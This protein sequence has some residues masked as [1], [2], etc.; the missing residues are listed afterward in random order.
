MLE[1]SICISSLHKRATLKSCLESLFKQAS[2]FQVSIAIVGPKPFEDSRIQWV[3]IP[4]ANVSLARN[5][6]LKEVQ[7]QVVYF[8]DDDCLLTN[9]H[10]LTNILKFC[11]S[12]QKPVL[13]FG[14]YVNGSNVDGNTIWQRTYNFICNLWL[15]KGMRLPDGPHILGG[16]FFICLEEKAEKSELQFDEQF[17][18]GAEEQGFI[19][20]VRQKGIECCY[21]PY[22]SIQHVVDGG[23]RRFFLRAWCHGTVKNQF[24]QEYLGFS[25]KI[26]LF[27]EEPESPIVKTLALLYL[28]IVYARSLFP[29]Y[30][31]LKSGT[32][33]KGNSNL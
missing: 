5:T 4:E 26:Q 19:R 15:R 30:F 31:L 16:N 13:G 6:L 17:N 11:H 33:I 10:H 29:P 20:R 32:R 27:F 25:K 12:K 22:L 24:P 28:S 18:F 2:P 7:G 1:L 8:L 23:F 14:N 3:H 9:P 21:L